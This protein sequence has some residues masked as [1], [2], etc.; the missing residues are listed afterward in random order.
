MS[1]QFWINASFTFLIGL[2]LVKQWMAST[3]TDKHERV[4]QNIVRYLER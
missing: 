4:L 3:Q 2:L 1:K